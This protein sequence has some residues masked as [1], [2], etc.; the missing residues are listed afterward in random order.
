MSNISEDKICQNCQDSF[1]IEADDFSFYQK[2]KVPPPTFCPNCRLQRRMA[3]R[4]ARSL[5]KDNCDKCGKDLISIFS[6][7]SNMTAY[8][9]SC[10]YGD[11]WDPMDYGVDYNFEKSFFEQFFKLQKRVP[12]EATGQRNS[13][14]CFYSN[15]NI[16]CKNCVLTF[17]CLESIN[18]YNSQVAVYSKDSNDLD[19][20]INGEYVYDALNSN[21][22]YNSKFIYLSNDC[23]DCSFL[24][25]CL[26][27]TNCFGCVN[28][29]NKKYHIYNKPYSKE[30]YQKE[31][32]KWDLGNREIFLKAK[33]K[34]IDLYYKIP[35]RFALIK[36]SIN[37]TG[38]DIS[39]TK[40]C[41]NCFFTR[42][43][44][45]NCKF[46][47][48]AGFL[49]KDSHDATFGG[50]K[51]ENFYETNGGM[52]S[53]NCFFVRAPYVS[54]N[55]EYSER[56]NNCSNCFGCVNLK[57]KQYCIFN[58]QYEKEEYFK[59]VEKIKNQ[60]NEIPYVDKK[61]RIYKY[62]EYFPIDKSLWAYNETWAH[63]YFPLTKEEA[64]NEGY[65]WKDQIEKNYKI[66]IKAKNLPNHIKDT[67]ESILN[68]I[69]EC[70]HADE[71]CNHN[72]PLAYK[73]LSNELSFYK[74]MN[75]ALPRLC[76]ICRH[77]ERFKFLY[78]LKLWDRE[79]MCSGFNSQDEK[80]EN[81]IEHYHK[82][83]KCKNIFKTT[84]SPE[85]LNI[86]YCEDC[87]KNEFI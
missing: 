10:W 33:Q 40:N 50:D 55:I 18:C 7:D 14:N 26:G 66:T 31:I 76:P 2:I 22:I 41:Q 83:E 70:G 78:P 54:K 82:E 42:N 24:Y 6:E 30:E 61:G 75:L 67:E 49:L 16:R 13:E 44:V 11:G 3:F 35:K 58:K 86:V 51:S 43:G 71:N 85:S 38:D 84:V 73:I 36:N 80:Y 57:N 19:N 53:H 39:N 29:R 62:G 69:I 27:C 65:N 74:K 64:L 5:Y 37:V 72:C 79:C 56:L 68:E 15:G 28:L 81:T 12:R 63:K 17:D 46:L 20:V 60:M 48:A 8:C 21:N 1:L 32:K 59:M 77:Y 25:N 34:F 4:E 9:S 87:Y 23:I 45:E 47:F 52:Q